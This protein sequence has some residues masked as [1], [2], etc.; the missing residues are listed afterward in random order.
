LIAPVVGALFDDSVKLLFGQVWPPLIAQE[1]L[2]GSVLKH[3]H[4]MQYTQSIP[5]LRR[6][7]G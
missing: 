7:A 1:D 5:Y 2:A 6:V 4:S 3:A